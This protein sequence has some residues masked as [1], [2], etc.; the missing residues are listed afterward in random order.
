MRR[1]SREAAN[2]FERKALAARMLKIL[3]NV[4]R[5]QRQMD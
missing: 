3:C 1:R 2:S 5:E 4:V